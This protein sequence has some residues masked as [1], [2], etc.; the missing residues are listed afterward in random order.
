MAQFLQHL[1]FARASLPG[2]GA[3]TI[4]GAV[5]GAFAEAVPSFASAVLASWY[6]CT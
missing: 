2:G 6:M 5:G 3:P 4:R 1:S